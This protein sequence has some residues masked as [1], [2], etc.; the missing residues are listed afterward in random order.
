MSPPPSFDVSNVPDSRCWPQSLAAGSL[1]VS[2]PA[3]AVT[4][5]KATT[6]H[7][8]AAVRPSAAAPVSAPAPRPRGAARS[9]A[10]PSSHRRSGAERHPGAARAVRLRPLRPAE[11]LRAALAA[12]R[13][14]RSRSSTPTTTRTPSPTWRTYRSQYGLPACTTANG[15]FKKVNQTGGTT[16]P[17]A[18]SGWA[19]EE[20]LDLDMVSAVCPSCH[21]LL[22]EATS[23]PR[24]T[25]APR[26][27]PR[28]AWAPSTSPTATAER[29]PPTPAT[30]TPT[31]T[32][33]RGH[34]R[35]VR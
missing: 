8:P 11:R 16:L 4:P 14:R 35:L 26:S 25:S 7:T 10:W 18:D 20:S 34:H 29:G 32:T 6:T 5:T 27:T 3:H 22:V 13:A 28:S 23:P 1:A 30:T 12:A 2:A 17:T 33:R 15:C 21:I 19:E 31:S 24:P 9:P